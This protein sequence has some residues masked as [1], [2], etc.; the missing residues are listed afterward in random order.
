MNDKIIFYS[1]HTTFNC[2]TSKRYIRINVY[3]LCINIDYETQPHLG[4]LSPLNCLSTHQISDGKFRPITRANLHLP[5]MRQIKNF[6]Q[7]SSTWKCS[8]TL[9]GQKLLFSI[10]HTLHLLNWGCYVCTYVTYC[11]VCLI[12]AN[13]NIY[14]KL[15]TKCIIYLFS[16]FKK[17]EACDNY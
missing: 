2:I 11:H 15:I 17:L 4:V 10:P 9:P 3:Q 14:I 16:Q 1:L 5:I 12:H 13:V 6:E 8:V 7:G